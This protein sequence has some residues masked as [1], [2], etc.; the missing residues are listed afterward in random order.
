MSYLCKYHTYKYEVAYN[1]QG[2]Y[3]YPNRVTVQVYLYTTQLRSLSFQEKR[4]KVT[5]RFKNKMRPRVV[6]METT[7]ALE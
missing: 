7:L 6:H 3:Q 2:P 5:T 4:L 1:T